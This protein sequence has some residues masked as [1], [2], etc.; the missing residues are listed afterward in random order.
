MQGAILEVF[1]DYFDN[2]TGTKLGIFLPDQRILLLDSSDFY[3]VAQDEFGCFNKKE[4]VCPD[5]DLTFETLVVL[6]ALTL[7]TAVHHY[8][9]RPHNDIGCII[10]PEKKLK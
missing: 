3:D 5:E 4:K 8:M 9:T 1:E 7:I 6:A 10:T 2:E